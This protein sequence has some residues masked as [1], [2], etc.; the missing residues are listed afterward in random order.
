MDYQQRTTNSP[1]LYT[2]E[3]RKQVMETLVALLKADT[4][5]A[6]AILVGSGAYGFRDRYSD[7][8][9]C[10][11]V[12]NA[13]DVLSAFCEFGAMVAQQFSLFQHEE[14]PR[15][16]NSY[17]HVFLLENYL[18][19]DIGFVALENLRATRKHWHVV[20]D[21]SDQLDQLMESTWAETT[22]PKISPE[23]YQSKLNDIWYFIMHSAVAATRNEPWRALTLLEEVRRRT[24]DLRGIRDGCET[25]LA[26][27]VDGMSARF[28]HRLAESLPISL[29]SREILRAL[30]VAVEM[31]FTEARELD[32]IHGEDHP[33]VLQERMMTFV[34]LIAVGKE[35]EGA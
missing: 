21:R 2:T 8:D 18:E 29:N 13:E 16:H 19:C 32:H 14:S 5:V 1:L 12:T 20:F 34:E 9:L 27:E 22:I 26:R 4:R 15:G 23:R 31:F 30:E 24:L 3:D 35:A 25:K 28:L 33:M 17:L 10:V 11:A 7:I 6:G